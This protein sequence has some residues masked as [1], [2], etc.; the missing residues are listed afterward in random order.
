MVARVVDVH[1][2]IK[3]GCEL[4]A[5]EEE[6]EGGLILRFRAG[7]RPE[8]GRD[9]EA[10]DSARFPTPVRDPSPGGRDVGVPPRGHR[11]VEVSRAPALR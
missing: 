3:E 1:R 5:V 11:R 10:R 6:D 2:L 4:D 9:R 8:A 7:G